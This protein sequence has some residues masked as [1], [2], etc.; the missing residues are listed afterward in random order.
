MTDVVLC[1][2]CQGQGTVLMPP[3]IDGD[4]RFWID[5]VSGGYTC[6]VCDGKGYIRL[7]EET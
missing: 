7:R 4:V 1:P 6:K 5:S 2:K 3:H